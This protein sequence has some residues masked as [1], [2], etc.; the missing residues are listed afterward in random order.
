MLRLPTERLSVALCPA[1]VGVEHIRTGWRHEESQQAQIDIAPQETGKPA[2][3]GAVDELAGWLGGRTPRRATTTLVLSNRFVRFALVPWCETVG[4]ATEETELALACFESRYG[5][6]TGWTVRLD[7]A[8]YGQPRIACAVETALIDAARQAFALHNL[9]C[10]EVRPAFIAGWNRFRREPN[11]SMDSGDGIFA[12]AESDTV[13][14]ATRRAGVWHSLR[15]A[16]AHI[17]ARALSQLIEREALLQGFAESLPAWV[18]MPGLASD[19]E[20]SA[21]WDKR[22]HVVANTGANGAA[23]ALARWGGRR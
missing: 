15:S 9:E 14:M 17:D 19:I 5:D 2:W 20:A 7:A 13:V 10:R 6:M 11:R 22:L 18:S 16:A 1:M 12:M 23:L 8:R 3:Q 21:D 4:S